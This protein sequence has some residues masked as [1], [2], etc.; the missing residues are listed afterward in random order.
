[1]S[2]CLRFCLKVFFCWTLAL[3]NF[4]FQIENKSSQYI[5]KHLGCRVRQTVGNLPHYVHNTR[6]NQATA[7]NIVERSFIKIYVDILCSHI[8]VFVVVVVLIILS[9]ISYARADDTETV[10]SHKLTT[11]LSHPTPSCISF[12]RLI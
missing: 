1:M 12:A 9:T 7:Q 2:L 6:N 4:I 5:Y 8:V 3:V 10:Y 11:A